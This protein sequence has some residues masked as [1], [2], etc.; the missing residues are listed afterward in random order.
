MSDFDPLSRQD[1]VLFDSL[2]LYTDKGAVQVTTEMIQQSFVIYEHQRKSAEYGVR[3]KAMLENNPE[4]ERG[5]IEDRLQEVAMGASVCI[6]VELGTPEMAQLANQPE[7]RQWVKDLVHG[8][9]V[10]R[11][12]LD[13]ELESGD[14]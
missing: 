13:N 4:I 2:T 3:T 12:R 7:W 8:Y 6:A 1:G 10:L 14:D 11:A 9:N 5:E